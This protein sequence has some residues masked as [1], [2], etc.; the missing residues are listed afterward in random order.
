[1][2]NLPLSLCIYVCVCIYSYIYINICMCTYIYILHLIDS[3]FSGKYWQIQQSIVVTIDLWKWRGEKREMWLRWE[4]RK[5]WGKLKKKKFPSSQFFSWVDKILT[6]SR[7]SVFLPVNS[8]LSKIQNTVL[9]STIYL[10]DLLFRNKKILE[11]LP[12]LLGWD[13]T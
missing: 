10:L 1:M 7:L 4:C 3:I 12:V 2:V 5:I 11:N 9:L 8:G 13:E 6:N